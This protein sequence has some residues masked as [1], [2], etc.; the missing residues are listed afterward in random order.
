[1]RSVK[2]LAGCATV[3]LLTGGPAVAAQTGGLAAPVGPHGF[4]LSA[5]LAYTERDV[6]DGRDDEVESL[7]I[8]FRIQFGFRDGLDLYGDVGVSDARFDHTNFDGGLGPS[9][10]VGLRCRLLDVQ[11]RA[12]KLI[13]D[14]QAEYSRSKDGS[15]RADFQAYHLA[16]YLLKEI[17]AAGRVGYFYPY[18]GL[19]AS[20]A[21]YDMNR[22][23]DDLENEDFLGIFGGADYFVTPTV[24][25]AGEIHLFDETSIHVGVGYRF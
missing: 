4:A 1:M 10:G 19:R 2:L 18:G 25:F 3:L 23:I 16:L 14:A 11:D 24:F 7:R 5:N 9:F 21:R 8:R 20:Y 15:K 17:G 22:G 12:L 6:E 13:L